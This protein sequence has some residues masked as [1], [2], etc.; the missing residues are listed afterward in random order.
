MP[1]QYNTIVREVRR[2]TLSVVTLRLGPLPLSLRW[3]A[4]QFVMLSCRTPGG[5]QR[6]AYSIANPP[7][8]PGFIDLTISAGGR[9][10]AFLCAQERPG[11]AVQI[12]GPYGRFTCTEGDTGRIGLIGAGTG[13]VPLMCIARYL[14]DRKASAS[15]TLLAGA[16]SEADIIYR[17]ELLAMEAARELSVTV[18]LT[19]PPRDGWSGHKGR[20]DEEIVAQ[21]LEKLVDRPERFYICGPPGLC[22]RVRLGLEACG[23]EAHQ[24]L[25]E[26]YE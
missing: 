25:E 26:V 4:G 3:D 13:I 7:T 19:N 10:S 5:I 16:R 14:H 22:L 6:R 11:L 8:R 12:S 17:E 18:S 2:E 23:V 21:W 20:I 24:I 9:L 1:Y 15:R